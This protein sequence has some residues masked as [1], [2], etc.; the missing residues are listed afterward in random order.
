[1]C[2]LVLLA[3]V[4]LA[5]TTIGGVIAGGGG[6]PAKGA[7]DAT[8]PWGGLARPAGGTIVGDAGGVSHFAGLAAPPPVDARSG[9]SL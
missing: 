8:L 4:A 3:L 2:V 1:M 6:P 7:V 9:L 5:L